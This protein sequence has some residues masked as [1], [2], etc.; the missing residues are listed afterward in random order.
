MNFFHLVDL[1]LTGE[2]VRRLTAVGG[3]MYGGKWE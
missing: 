1:I 2:G 3:V